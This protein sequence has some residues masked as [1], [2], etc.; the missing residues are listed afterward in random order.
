MLEYLGVLQNMYKDAKT[1]S[2]T[3]IDSIIWKFTLMVRY[4]F[5]I[6]SATAIACKE[7]IGDRRR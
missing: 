5:Y 4:L 1:D 6:Y 7:S 2:E 3:E